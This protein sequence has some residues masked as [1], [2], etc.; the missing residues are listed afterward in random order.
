MSE[1]PAKTIVE[2]FI[3]MNEHGDSAVDDTVESAVYRLRQNYLGNVYRIVKRT[4]LM[5]PPRIVETEMEDIPDEPADLPETSR[6]L[7]LSNKGSTPSPGGSLPE[8]SRSSHH[9]G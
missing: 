8:A 4:Y 6:S 1:Q 7:D 9:S 5:S 3:A 2:V